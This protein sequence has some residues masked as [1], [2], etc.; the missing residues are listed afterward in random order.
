MNKTDI[1]A[2][3]TRFKATFL[4]AHELEID[5]DNINTGFD[6]FVSAFDQKEFETAKKVLDLTDSYIIDELES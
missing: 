3:E 4:M 1:N 6:L 2:L 5:K